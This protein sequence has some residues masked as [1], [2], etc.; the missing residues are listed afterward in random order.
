MT[1]ERWLLIVDRKRRDLYE[2]LRREFEGRATVVLDRR[3]SARAYPSDQERRRGLE[4][5]EA[6]VW[7]DEGYCV[8]AQSGATAPERQAARSIV[9]RAISRFSDSRSLGS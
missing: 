7:H 1:S 5:L 2:Y 4:V 9:R 3:T 8:I 6:A